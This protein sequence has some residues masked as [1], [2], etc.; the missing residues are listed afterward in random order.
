[1]N[2]ED[3]WWRLF[4]VYVGI[5]SLFLILKLILWLCAIDEDRF[6]RIDSTSFDNEGFD[7]KK[8][9]RNTN[10]FRHLIDINRSIRQSVSSK[11]GGY[12]LL[13]YI[14]GIFYL[15]LLRLIFDID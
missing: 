3:M 10:P 12:F 1:M 5:S 14:Y 2:Y 6:F 7:R 11:I 4:W 8:E 13:F 9:Q 15:I